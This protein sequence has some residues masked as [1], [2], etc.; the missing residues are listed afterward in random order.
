MPPMAPHDSLS[1]GGRGTMTLPTRSDESETQ[2]GELQQAERLPVTLRVGA[3]L[4]V[5]AGGAPVAR[6]AH[7]L[8]GFPQTR[9][10]VGTA[11]RAGVV[12][13][14][15][16]QALRTRIAAMWPWEASK[17]TVTKQKT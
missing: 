10:A 2:E 8:P 1:P 11:V 7:T 3:G 17:P 15:A 6:P 16:P 13:V 14:G 5:L 9:V 12:A 4:T